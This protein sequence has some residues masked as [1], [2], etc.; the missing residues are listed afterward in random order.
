MPDRR[1]GFEDDAE[2]DDQPAGGTA[3]QPDEPDTDDIQGADPDRTV[4]V[5]A[6]PSGQFIAVGLV[7]DWRRQVP[8]ETV[9]QRTQAAAND[10][11]MAV[12]ARKLAEPDGDSLSAENSADDVGAGPVSHDVAADPGAMA[13]HVLRLVDSVIGELARFERQ[14]VGVI[15]A[16]VSADSRGRHVTAT[17]MHGQIVD[18][19]ID[20]RWLHAAAH[21]EIEHELADALRRVQSAAAPPELAAGPSGPAIAELNRLVRDP[22]TFLRQLGLTP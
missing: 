1:W 3:R 21:K 11:T 5:T 10:A 19:S 22:V 12:L 18:V 17:S 15:G 6:N 4:T 20:Q 8:P 14:L 16:R 9:G 2:W 13:E 7:A